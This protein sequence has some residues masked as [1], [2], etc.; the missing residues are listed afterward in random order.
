VE[1]E[2]VGADLIGPTASLMQLPANATT[3]HGTVNLQQ[4]HRDIEVPYSKL[5]KNNA[6]SYTIY[7]FLHITVTCVKSAS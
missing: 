6:W 5:A 1:E 2:N 4:E 3:T 7:T